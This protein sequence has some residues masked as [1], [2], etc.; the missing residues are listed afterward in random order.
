MTVPLAEPPQTNS[1]IDSIRYDS[2]FFI[3][4]VRNGVMSLP[5]VTQLIFES[6]GDSC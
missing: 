5:E 1:I 6:E 2:G 4:W 3:L